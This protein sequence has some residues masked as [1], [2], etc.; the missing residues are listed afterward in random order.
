M[1]QRLRESFTLASQSISNPPVYPSSFASANHPSSLQ[2]A[3]VREVAEEMQLDGVSHLIFPKSTAHDTYTTEKTI[4]AA[5]GE[6]APSLL[7]HAF[8]LN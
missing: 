3:V 1:P 2:A 8:Q 6:P 4:A 5:Y 7:R